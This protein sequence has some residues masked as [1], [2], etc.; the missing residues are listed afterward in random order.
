MDK[1]S[2]DILL[3]DVENEDVLIALKDF[4]EDWKVSQNSDLNEYLR[5]YPGYFKS[6]K[7]TREA[8]RLVLGYAKELMDGSRSSVGFYENKIWTLDNGDQVRF[9]HY[10]EREIAK[11]MQGITSAKKD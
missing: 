4:S 9:A 3:W 2:T 7:S 5:S 10:Y 8:M 6:D 11:L 1:Q